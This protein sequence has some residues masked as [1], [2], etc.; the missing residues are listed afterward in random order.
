MMDFT[1]KELVIEIYQLAIVC[2]SLLFIAFPFALMYL[3]FTWRSD[4]NKFRQIMRHCMRTIFLFDLILAIIAIPWFHGAKYLNMFFLPGSL[5]G[6]GFVWG[7][8]TTG[9]MN[10]FEMRV[11]LILSFIY[12]IAIGL[13]LGIVAHIREEIRKADDYK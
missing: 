2:A 3:I 6:W 12:Y 9:T 5:L 13:E 11:T 10:L 7:D 8:T 4:K 1:T